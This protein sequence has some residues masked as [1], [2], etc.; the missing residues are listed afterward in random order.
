MSLLNVKSEEIQRLERELAEERK[1]MEGLKVEL[2]ELR[3]S[4]EPTGPVRAAW[5]V[6]RAQWTQERTKW[7]SDSSHWETQR[8][9]M[10]DE[11]SA[12]S[13]RVAE[14][15]DAAVRAEEARVKLSE[16]EAERVAWTNE[17]DVMLNNVVQRTEELAVLTKVRG[18]DDQDRLKWEVERTLWVQEKA[19][20]ETE[21]T[22]LQEKQAALLR[23][24]NELSASVESM[25]ATKVSAEKDRDFFREQYVQAS[26]FVGSVREENVELENRV[27]IAEGQAQEGVAAIRALFEVWFSRPV[28]CMDMH[29][30]TSSGPR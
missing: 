4:S 15:S 8:K 19:G 22:A 21:R 1:N 16:L 29:L 7:E 20:W 3:K 28:A 17:R 6:E 12:L 24:I 18:E 10:S 26:G 2:A 9:E 5:E 11:N 30:L 25:R 27:K 23:S 14:L 13:A